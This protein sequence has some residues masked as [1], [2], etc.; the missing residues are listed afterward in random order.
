MIVNRL[1]QHHFGEGLVATPSDFGKQGEPP[2]HPELLD[3]LAD[4]LIRGGWKLKP[5]HRLMVTSAVYRQSSAADAA[6][7]AVDPTNRLLWRYNRRRLEGEAIRDTLLSLAGTLNGQ[8][9]GRAGR[10]ERSLRGS[11]Y[12]EVKRSRL[13]LFL[14]TFDSPD[15][16]SGLARP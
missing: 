1:W 7:A 3:W 4:E 12:L 15:F 6:K 13:P 14:R 8:L 5:L 2:T 10:D 16:V 9:Y 11:L